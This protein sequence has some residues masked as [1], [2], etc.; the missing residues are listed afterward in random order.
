MVSADIIG[1]R[2]G[3]AEYGGTVEQLPHG[4][5]RVLFRTFDRGTD[6]AHVSERR[7]SLDA[8]QFFRVGRSLL[9]YTDLIDIRGG[10]QLESKLPCA[11]GLGVFREHFSDFLKFQY[12]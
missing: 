9:P 12:I 2:P 8:D 4:Q 3:S 1:E 10:S 7:L 5:H 6:V 11:V